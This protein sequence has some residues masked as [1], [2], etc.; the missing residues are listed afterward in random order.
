MMGERPSGTTPARSA[1]VQAAMEVTR[2]FGVEPLLDIGSTDANIPISMGLAAIAIGGGG[3]SGN[4][5]TS[6]EWFDPLH[7]DQGIQRLLALIG[8]LAG[9]D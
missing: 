8:V 3:I 9:L 1:I 4:V 6:E 2:R 7:R 5:H